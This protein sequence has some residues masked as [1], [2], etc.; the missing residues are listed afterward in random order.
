MRRPPEQGR[1]AHGGTLGRRRC[2]RITRV[3]AGP[4]QRAAPHRD[5]TLGWS[6]PYEYTYG[7]GGPIRKVTVNLP[8]KLLERARSTT[9]LGITETIFGLMRASGI[10]LHLVTLG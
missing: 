7:V 5:H 9:G 6:V 10:P 4:Y 3:P 1:E 2:Q 8:A